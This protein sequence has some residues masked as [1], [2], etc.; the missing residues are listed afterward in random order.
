MAIPRTVR[1]VVAC[2][3]DVKLILE[4]AFSVNGQRVWPTEIR[5]SAI[6]Y[7]AKM[8][9]V[10]GE[11]DQMIPTWNPSV[12]KFHKDRPQLR[13]GMEKIIQNYR[14]GGKNKLPD[15]SDDK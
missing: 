8:R 2:A 9:A 13:W 6:E 5:R 7:Q 12:N 10:H 3:C 4:H 1:V 15:A 11:V 14:A